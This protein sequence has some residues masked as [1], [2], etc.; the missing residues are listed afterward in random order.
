MR[1]RLMESGRIVRADVDRVLRGDEMREHADVMFAS[2]YTPG[3]LRA[4]SS[5]APDL[6]SASSRG[7]SVAGSRAAS[8]RDDASSVAPSL[9]PAEPKGGG[10]GDAFGI[11]VSIA[12][13]RRGRSVSQTLSNPFGVLSGGA[14]S[15]SV[16]SSISDVT[17]SFVS[18]SR[19]A[20]SG[21]GVRGVRHV[22][23][24]SSHGGSSAGN[25][26]GEPRRDHSGMPIRDPDGN[27]MEAQFKMATITFDDDTPPAPMVR[28][29]AP[30]ATRLS[31]VKDFDEAVFWCLRGVCG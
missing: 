5:T 10:G 19:L 16:A 2:R 29:V 8:A 24:E 11:F 4:A 30:S 3:P 12:P 6:M 17:G 9:D 13:P 21:Q 25:A 28:E 26:P 14:S 1:V 15:R 22:A 7:G 18:A 20:P 27:G 31:A 23:A